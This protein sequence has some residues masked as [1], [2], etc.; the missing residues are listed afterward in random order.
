[1]LLP[2][3]GERNGVEQLTGG[4]TAEEDRGYPLDHLLVTKLSKT[5]SM[6]NLVAKRKALD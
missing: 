5:A 2:L 6:R 3:E 1:M 4:G